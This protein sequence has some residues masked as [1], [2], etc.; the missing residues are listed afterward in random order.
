MYTYL[1][2]VHLGKIRNLMIR[3]FTF[4]LFNDVYIWIFVMNTVFYNNFYELLVIIFFFFFATDVLAP[5]CCPTSSL[6]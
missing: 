4:P 3:L 1:L 6:C 2:N 5:H